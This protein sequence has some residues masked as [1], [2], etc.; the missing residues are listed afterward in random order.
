MAVERTPCR[1]PAPSAR[2]TPRC[3]TTPHTTS[4]GVYTALVKTTADFCSEI[5]A[6]EVATV[7]KDKLADLLTRGAQTFAADLE[8][9]LFAAVVRHRINGVQT[10]LYASDGQDRL[11]IAIEDLG[12]SEEL[13]LAHL[14]RC[15]RAAAKL[16]MPK[17]V[18]DERAGFGGLERELVGYSDEVAP[19]IDR[20]TRSNQLP[21]YTEDRPF[22]LEM[23]LADDGELQLQWAELLQA[24]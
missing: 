7:K 1:E 23:R 13:A 11:A 6:V 24:R 22:I 19:T 12:A 17:R 15:R 14:D 2:R 21:R 8:L 20:L 16:H 9:L 5:E 18:I 10:H 4:K 3:S